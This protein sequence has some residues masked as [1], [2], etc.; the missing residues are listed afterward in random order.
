MSISEKQEEKDV[1]ARKWADGDVL[2]I[3]SESSGEWAQ[4]ENLDSFVDASEMQ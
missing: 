1:T 4:A 3:S 2:I